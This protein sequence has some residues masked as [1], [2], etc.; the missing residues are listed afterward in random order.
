MRS[1]RQWHTP[2]DP[3]ATKLGFRGWHSRGYLPHFDLPGLVQFI[4]YRLDDAMP[5]A[6][7]HEWATLLEID[8]ELKRWTKIEDYLD[9]GRGSCLLRDARAA[10]IVE[11][12]WLHLDGQEY[13]LL[14]WVVM[15]NHVHLLVE[16]WQTP[17][18][19]LIQNWK[20]FTA[21]RIN[22]LLGRRGQLWQ[23]DY[24][25]RYIRDAAHYRKVVHYIEANPVKAGLVKA[26]EQWPFS[27]ARFRDEYNQLTLP[28]KPSAGR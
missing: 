7:R 22:R 11:E 24:W 19:E 17:Q 1:K 26:P 8:D 4:N 6:L 14:A 28:G 20:G 18:A 16:I 3:E 12:N 5:A 27:S 13:R 21:R 10:A 9:R 2:P 15:P 23:D 25:D